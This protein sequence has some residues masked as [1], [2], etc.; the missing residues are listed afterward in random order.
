MRGGERGRDGKAGK[1]S[2]VPDVRMGGNG[3]GE[4]GSEVLVL[5][6]TREL[7]VETHKQ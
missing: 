6:Q 4:L 7:P 2:R 3:E 5:A 1:K